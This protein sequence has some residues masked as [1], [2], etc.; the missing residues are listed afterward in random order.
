MVA[1]GRG[2]ARACCELKPEAGDDT[3]TGLPQ[4]RSLQL[5][6]FSESTYG[7]RGVPLLFSVLRLSIG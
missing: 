6:S 2:E 7:V 1:G 3:G 5:D 4:L